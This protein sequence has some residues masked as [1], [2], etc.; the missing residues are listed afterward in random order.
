MRTNRY[1]LDI[2]QSQDLF[3]LQIA[4][5]PC[6]LGYGAIAKMLEVHPATVRDDNPY[7]DWIANYNAEDYVSAVQ[8]GTGT[9][10]CH[11]YIYHE[12]LVQKSFA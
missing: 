11:I 10:R 12:L 3:A 9:F 2:G 5:A 7:W 6:L 1:V 8:K 4:L